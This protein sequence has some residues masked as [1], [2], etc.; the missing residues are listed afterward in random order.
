MDKLVNMTDT[1]LQKIGVPK[2]LSYSMNRLTPP[3][4]H[5]YTCGGVIANRQR[6]SASTTR[7]D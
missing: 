1:D 2:V 3:P 4:P 6:I 5:M 7:S